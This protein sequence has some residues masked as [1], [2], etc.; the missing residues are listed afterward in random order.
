[1]ESKE[2]DALRNIRVPDT[3]GRHV[4]QMHLNPAEFDELGFVKHLFSN[5]SLVI[6]ARGLA[7]FWDI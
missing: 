3:K 6:V 2:I 4:F 7:W 5:L 1:M